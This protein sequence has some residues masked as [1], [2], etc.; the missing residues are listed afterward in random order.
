MENPSTTMPLHAPL[1]INNT[2][3]PATIVNDVHEMIYNSMWINLF[4]IALYGAVVTFLKDNKQ[5]KEKKKDFTY[6]TLTFLIVFCLY[7]LVN[8]YNVVKKIH[9][10][11][12]TL[13]SS[14]T[15]SNIKLYLETRTKNMSFVQTLR[16]IID[17]FILFS[18]IVLILFIIIL[19]ILKIWGIKLKKCYLYTLINIFDPIYCVVVA[20]Y[21]LFNFCYDDYEKNKLSVNLGSY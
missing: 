2:P 1:V 8:I 11:Y 20:F 4:L 19:S 15:F 10:D 14:V 12:H 5:Q 9:Q 13:Y 3:Q 7:T 18:T 17:F 6:L 21:L 16:I